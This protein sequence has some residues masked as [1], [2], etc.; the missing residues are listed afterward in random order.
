MKDVE[1]Q[2][3]KFSK[4]YLW[5]EINGQSNKIEIYKNET[6]KIKEF[7]HT[8]DTWAKTKRELT[9]RRNNIH[10]ASNKGLITKYS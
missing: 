6:N 9:E 4:V 1:I 8:E 3:V 5:S 10:N 7:L 2:K